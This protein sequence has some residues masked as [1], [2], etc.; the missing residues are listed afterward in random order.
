ME[1]LRPPAGAGRGR[2]H[3]GRLRPEVEGLRIDQHEHVAVRRQRVLDGRQWIAAVAEEL[4]IERRLLCAERSAG[5]ARRAARALAPAT[6]NRRIRRPSTGAR[7]GRASPQA[8]TDSAESCGHDAAKLVSR[9]V[10]IPLVP[11]QVTAHVKVAG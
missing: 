9:G 7:W 11:R 3:E 5:S 10:G 1:L 4:G 8:V 2:R 6:P